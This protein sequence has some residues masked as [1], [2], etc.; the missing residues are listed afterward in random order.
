MLYT[1]V[2]FGLKA[3]KTIERLKKLEGDSFY[4]AH[5]DDGGSSKT[6]FGSGNIAFVV[7]IE[8]GE[9]VRAKTGHSV[10][11]LIQEK[12]WS[13]EALRD[14]VEVPLPK[15]SGITKI[16]TRKNPELAELSTVPA[17]H[18]FHVQAVYLKMALQLADVR[19]NRNP[20]SPYNPLALWDRDERGGDVYG[21]I[22]PYLT[23]LKKECG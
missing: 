17:L 7:P 5:L 18:P 11:R 16:G 13:D 4:L 10:Y 9:E 21:V 8:I 23:E 1:S 15:A 2:A 6:I 19:G 20:L 12:W 3:E 22:M 14:M